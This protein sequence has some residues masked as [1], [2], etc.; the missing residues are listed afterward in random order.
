VLITNEALPNLGLLS[1]AGYP[2]WPSRARGE[3]FHSNQPRGRRFK[4]RAESNA[5]LRPI[6]SLFAD[7]RPRVTGVIRD[8]GTFDRAQ[9]PLDSRHKH[10]V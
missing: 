2:P 1:P 5:G 3:S 7:Y 10:G 8:Y 4:T 9:A 6:F